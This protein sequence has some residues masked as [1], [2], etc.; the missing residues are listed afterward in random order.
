MAANGRHD[1]F[2]GLCHAVVL[3]H[4]AT[5]PES[6]PSN[7]DGGVQI[8]TTLVTVR[9]AAARPRGQGPPY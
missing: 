9:Y 3:M 8:H 5:C 2:T 1:V 4:T 7:S 6:G